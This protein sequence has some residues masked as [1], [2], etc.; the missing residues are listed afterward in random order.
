VIANTGLPYNPD[1]PDEI[2]KEVEDF[3]ANAPTPSLM[4]MQKALSAM[5]GSAHFATQFAYWQ[6]FCWENEDRPI[7]FMMSMTME[8]RSNLASALKFFLHSLGV[9]SP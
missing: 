1:V 9:H 3:R 4:S 6:K 7:G 5:G 8:Q 2:V